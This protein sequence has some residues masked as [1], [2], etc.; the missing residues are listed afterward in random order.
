MTGVV[1]IEWYMMQPYHEPVVA[2]LWAFLARLYRGIAE[3]FGRAAL[4]AEYNY[5]LAAGAGI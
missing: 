1:V 2:R 4:H 5:Y 3:G